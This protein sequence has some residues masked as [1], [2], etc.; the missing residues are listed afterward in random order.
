M[1]STIYNYLWPLSGCLWGWGGGARI[2]GPTTQMSQSWS[3]IMQHRRC[4]RGISKIFP[5]FKL[6]SFIGWIADIFSYKYLKI[7]HCRVMLKRIIGLLIM[8]KQSRWCPLNQSQCRQAEFL[9]MTSQ[10]EG[11]RA[12]PLMQ[13]SQL[14]CSR[15]LVQTVPVNTQPM[16]MFLRPSFDQ[17]Y[18]MNLQQY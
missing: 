10:S 9:M 16:M 12:E 4:Q 15:D 18:S 17:Q 2:K 7:F 11:R 1:L 5:C 14:Y 6:L 3:T 13:A 8:P